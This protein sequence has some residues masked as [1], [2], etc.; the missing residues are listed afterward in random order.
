MNTYETVPFEAAALERLLAD[1]GE[2]SLAGTARVFTSIQTFVVNRRGYLVRLPVEPGPDYQDENAFV[3]DGNAFLVVLDL[4]GW[5]TLIGERRVVHPYDRSDVTDS[6]ISAL[7]ARA[8][9]GCT[10]AVIK[11][12]VFWTS[13]LNQ[14]HPSAPRQLTSANTTS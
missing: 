6:L 2:R 1:L 3:H 12:G 14:G 9:D 7:E 10:R 5:E 11:D 13:F 4:W 8:R